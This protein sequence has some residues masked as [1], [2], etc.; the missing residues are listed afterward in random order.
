[1]FDLKKKIMSNFHLLDVVDRGRQ[2]QHQAV[3]NLKN[4]T[5]FKMLSLIDFNMRNIWKNRAR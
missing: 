5:V 1:M 2:T 4:I 3:E